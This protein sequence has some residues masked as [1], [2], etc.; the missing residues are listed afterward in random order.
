MP[1]R[2]CEMIPRS[3]F[4]LTRSDNGKPLR[5]NGYR[6]YWSRFEAIDRK[7]LRGNYLHGC[8][9]C[10][11]RSRVWQAGLVRVR[12]WLVLGMEEPLRE[13]INYKHYFVEFNDSQPPAVQR[14]IDFVL[15]LIRYV[16]RVPEKFLTLPC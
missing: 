3:G 9:Q 12:K 14:K 5:G 15:D 7:P 10:A 16:P 1:Q 6:L 2:T 13:I 4:L 11:V 8:A